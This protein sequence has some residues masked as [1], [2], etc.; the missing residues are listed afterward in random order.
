M[1]IEQEACYLDWMIWLVVTR[2][3]QQYFSAEA[4]FTC[5][6][7]L[8]RI[9]DLAMVLLPSDQQSSRLDLRGFR[10]EEPR[11]NG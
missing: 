4:D 9:F 11:Q 6:L 10:T 3:V 1:P 7:M 8:T 5:P 2:R